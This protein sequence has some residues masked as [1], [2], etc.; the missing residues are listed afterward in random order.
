[1]QQDNGPFLW[2][3]QSLEWP[4]IVGKKST[5]TIVK[6]GT[7]GCLTPNSI[8]WNIMISVD[9]AVI[10][11]SLCLLSLCALILVCLKS[12]V[13]SNLE[14]VCCNLDYYSLYPYQLTAI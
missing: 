8:W 11:P 9:L 6:D 3:A 1:M 10:I 12:G 4:V 2:W 5:V 13:L 14:F 7:Y